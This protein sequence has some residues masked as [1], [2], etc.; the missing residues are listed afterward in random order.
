MDAAQKAAEV[1][2]QFAYAPRTASA[3]SRSL[4]LMDRDGLP[5]GVPYSVS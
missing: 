1:I 4:A 5:C 3:H 2:K